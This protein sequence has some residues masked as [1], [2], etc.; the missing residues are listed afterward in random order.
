MRVEDAKPGTVVA[1]EGG[2]PMTIEEID[3]PTTALALAPMARCTWFDARG[4]SYSQW[5]RVEALEPTKFRL[6]YVHGEG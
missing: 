3:A 2:L 6:V 5:F 1:Y 4:R